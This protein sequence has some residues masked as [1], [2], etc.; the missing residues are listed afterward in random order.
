MDRWDKV[1]GSLWR[2]WRGTEARQSTAHCPP[3]PLSFTSVSAEAPGRDPGCAHPLR[4]Q[5]RVHTMNFR[6]STFAL[7]FLSSPAALQKCQFG[8]QGPESPLLKEPGVGEGERV[9]T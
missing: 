6:F 8:E 9:S 7:S 5:A 4:L 1:G 2:S 3:H